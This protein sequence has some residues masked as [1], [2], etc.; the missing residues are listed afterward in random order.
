MTDIPRHELA[1]VTV[2][3]HYPVPPADVY[4][5]LSSREAM[6][7]WANPDPS[8]RT[9][10]DPWDFRAGGVVVTRMDPPE[11]EPWINED[12][13]QEILPE[14]RIVQTSSLHYKGLLQFAGVVVMSLV[15]EGG[16]T[17]LTI[18]EHGVFPDGRDAP[19][20]HELG[21]TQMLDQLGDFLKG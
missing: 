16:G 17:R 8:F 6:L 10:I 20:N 3:R 15:P 13:Y 1:T 7:V 21:W 11:G 12:R 19:R 2:T 4:S 14:A 18:D 5:A 9:T